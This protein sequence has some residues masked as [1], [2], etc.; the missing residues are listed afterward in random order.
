MTIA[1]RMGL[2]DELARAAIAYGGTAIWLRAGDDADLIPFLERAL[3]ARADQE[4][5]LRVRLLGRLAGALRGEP[6]AAR[7]DGA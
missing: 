2:A 3:Q 1:E 7:Q 5:A 4:D 6:D